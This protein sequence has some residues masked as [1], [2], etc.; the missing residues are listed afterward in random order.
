MWG[1]ICLNKTTLL[2]MPPD[3]QNTKK[4]KNPP[5]NLREY[6]KYDSDK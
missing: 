4:K 2:L 1:K 5:W 6:V 3:M